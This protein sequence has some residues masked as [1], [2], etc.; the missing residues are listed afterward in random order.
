MSVYLFQFRREM[1]E[2][3]RLFNDAQSSYIPP[4]FKHADDDFCDIVDMALRVDPS[5]DG[6]AHKFQG[7]RYELMVGVIFSEHQRSDL[8]TPYAAFQIERTGQG[9]AGISLDRNMREEGLRIKVD[10]MPTSRLHH[11]NTRR[12]Q[13]FR[14]VFCS[15]YAV[16]EVVLVHD[17]V[18]AHCHG[19]Q[20]TARKA[21]IGG[22]SLG[23]DQQVPAMQCQIGI[24]HRQKTSD[25]GEGVFLCAH[26]APIRIRKHLPDNLLYGLV[27]VTFFAQLYE[28]CILGKPA[29]IN[30]HRYPEFRTDLTCRADILHTDR[31]SAS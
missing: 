19:F 8:H 29:R 13:F 31:L 6:K 23:D 24:P 12:N 14:E 1:T 22:E 5:W 28:I 11:G 21:S 3:G 16:P 7:C 9:L 17:L 25:V 18:K 20:V 10:G 2:H 15:P 30:E 4:F 26:G 27:G